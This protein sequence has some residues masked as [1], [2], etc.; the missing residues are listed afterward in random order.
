MNPPAAIPAEDTPGDSRV[1]PDSV[2]SSRDP[3]PFEM[4]AALAHEINQPLAAILGNAQAARRFVSGGGISRDELLAILDDI[5]S[6]TQRAGEVIR[7]L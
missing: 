7:N 5:I 1:P 3:M 6:D 2:R 4:A